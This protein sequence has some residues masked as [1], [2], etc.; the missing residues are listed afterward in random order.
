MAKRGPVLQS[1]I[2]Q[3]IGQSVPRFLLMLEGE[4]KY[5]IVGR[6]V[7]VE[8]HISRVPEGNDQLA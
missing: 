1:S 8:R 3:T 6:F 5:S 7:M 2:T 4:D